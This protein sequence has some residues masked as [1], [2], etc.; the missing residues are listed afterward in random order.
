VADKERG[1]EMLQLD[2]DVK[3]DENGAING[4]EL[5]GQLLGYA[6]MLLAPYTNNCPACTDD[7]FSVL[8]NQAL[9]RLH[10]GFKAGQV[11]STVLVVGEG[12]Q[13][14]ISS[15]HLETMRPLIVSLL[16]E[17]GADHAHH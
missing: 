5:A 8:A 1:K 17:A 14:E 15:A 7:L 13:Q 6:G 2:F 9:E 3:P 4:V 11:F 10:E 12:D 16:S